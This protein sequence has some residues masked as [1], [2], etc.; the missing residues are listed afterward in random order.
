MPDNVD[1]AELE[2]RLA[3]YL[4]APQQTE[5]TQRGYASSAARFA[6]LTRGTDQLTSPVTEREVRKFL[7]YALNGGSKRTGTPLAAATVQGMMAALRAVHSSSWGEFILDS[8]DCGARLER[9]LLGYAKT[10]AKH[11]NVCKATPLRAAALRR[12]VHKVV[13]GRGADQWHV[14]SPARHRTLVMLCVG[15]SVGLRADDLLRLDHGDVVFTDDGDLRLTLRSSKGTNEP[16]SFELRPTYMITCPVR[17]L[18][19][20]VERCEQDGASKG[21]PLFCC[22]SRVCTDPWRRVSYKAALGQLKLLAAEHEDP[23]VSFHSLR[24]GYAT[25]ALAQ[26]ATVWQLQRT[27]RHRKLTTTEGYVRA[28]QRARAAKASR[29]VFNG[30]TS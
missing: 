24:T 11:R 27:L 30:G 22:V 4:T 26:G 21:S 14:L 17:A 25:E 7:V 10:A 6:R 5:R 3:Q 9:V 8:P 15:H 28:D 19:S 29:A 1:L 2:A 23:T 16:V 13:A 12:W 18:R 20:W